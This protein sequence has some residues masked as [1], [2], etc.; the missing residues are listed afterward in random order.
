MFILTILYTT[1]L[2]TAYW[3]AVTFHVLGHLVV[4]LVITNLL[5]GRDLDEMAGML[6][7]ILNGL[8]VLMVIP[9]AMV[10]GVSHWLFNRPAKT[11]CCR[12]CGYNLRGN[13]RAASCPECGQML[14][15]QDQLV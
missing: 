14:S 13:P 10:L 11:G 3:G 5:M 9:G 12:K 2:L 15:A 6:V 4:Y 7:L 8:V 1:L